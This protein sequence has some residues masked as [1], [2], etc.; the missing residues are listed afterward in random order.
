MQEEKTNMTQGGCLV[1]YSFQS[2]ALGNHPKCLSPD[3]L[4]AG[5][6][7]LTKEEVRIIGIDKKGEK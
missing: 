1:E 7:I 4:G 6:S 3:K 5:D 2:L